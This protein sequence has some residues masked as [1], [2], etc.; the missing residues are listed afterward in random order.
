VQV[1]N[2]WGEGEGTDA[3]NVEA[4]MKLML[5]IAA[6]REKTANDFPETGPTPAFAALCSR[7]AGSCAAVLQ[8]W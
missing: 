1:N 4:A 7:Q 8:P 2:M 5:A 3:Q 6:F